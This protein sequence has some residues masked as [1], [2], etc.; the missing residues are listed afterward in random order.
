MKFLKSEVAS[1]SWKKA[2]KCKKNREVSSWKTGNE[3]RKKRLSD[4]NE[5]LET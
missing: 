1:A 5:V 4:G 3:V 2:A